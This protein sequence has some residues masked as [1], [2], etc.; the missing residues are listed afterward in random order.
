MAD[1]VIVNLKFE[2]FF[3]G[4]EGGLHFVGRKRDFV[5]GRAGR[6]LLDGSVELKYYRISDAVGAIRPTARQ[7][8]ENTGCART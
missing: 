7:P 6:A 8:A 4:L 5:L 1:I 2:I 3:S